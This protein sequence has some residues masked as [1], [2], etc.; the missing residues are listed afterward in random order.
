MITIPPVELEQFITA[1]EQGEVIGYPTEA[2]FGLGCD[3]SPQSSPPP[4]GVIPPTRKTLIVL[5][6]WYRSLRISACSKVYSVTPST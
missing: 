3:A 5:G 1:F 6:T 2:V 4:G